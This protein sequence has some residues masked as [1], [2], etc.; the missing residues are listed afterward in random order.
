MLSVQREAQANAECGSD[1][2]RNSHIV[3]GNTKGCS[4]SYANRY[5][6]S[7]VFVHSLLAGGAGLSLNIFK[8]HSG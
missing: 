7:Q 2:D 5:S 1:A 3:Q 4:N 8:S 6:Q